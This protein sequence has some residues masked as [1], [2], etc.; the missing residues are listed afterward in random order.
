KK[1]TSFRIIGTGRGFQFVSAV[2]P[3]SGSLQGGRELSIVRKFQV[4]ILRTMRMEPQYARCGVD[5]GL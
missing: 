1:Q 2:R 4:Y 5:S 3:P